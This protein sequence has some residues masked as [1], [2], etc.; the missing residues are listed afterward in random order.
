MALID[1]W[2]LSSYFECY[3]STQTIA[4]QYRLFSSQH[5][6]RYDNELT[7]NNSLIRNCDCHLASRYTRSADRAESQ[8]PVSTPCCA[9]DTVV[10]CRRQCPCHCVALFRTR[11][12]NH[13]S[14]HSAA[15]ADY[16][17]RSAG[18][19]V[20]ATSVA[21]ACTIDRLRLCDAGYTDTDLAVCFSG[22]VRSAD[23]SG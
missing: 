20:P 21:P 18:I 15:A 5:W 16:I 7:N 3:C 13:R 22:L 17:K 6:T 8:R 23:F 10:R 4:F 19:T 14:C 12:G 11:R 9:V 2:K 1:S